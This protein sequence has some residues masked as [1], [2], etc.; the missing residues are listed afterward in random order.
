[1]YRVG[2]ES[3]LGIVRH[4][5]HLTIEP[6]IPGSWSGFS[7]QWR[8]G[9]SVYDIRVD[10]PEHATGGRLEA[11][12]DG[13]RVDPAAIPLVDDGRSRRI[14]I[15]LAAVCPSDASGPE[16]DDGARDQR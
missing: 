8:H 5:D 11:R 1:M 14:E 12:L 9:R 13:E 3:I 16:R 15:V 6:R 2:L 7:V 4:G 10:N